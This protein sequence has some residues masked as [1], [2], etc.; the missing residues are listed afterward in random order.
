M[1]APRIAVIVVNYNGGHLVA[2]CLASVLRQTLA[3]ARVIVVDNGSSDGSAEAVRDRFRR[4]ELV[5][6]GGNI[7]FA[8]ASNLGAARAENCDW[9]ALLNPDAFPEPR[10]LE[11]LAAAASANPE[12]SSFGSRMLMD[13]DPSRFDGVGDVYHPSG[14]CWREAHGRPAAGAFE[15]PA[16]I[17]SPCAGAALYRRQVFL[18]SGGFDEDFFC[19]MEDVDLGF[20]LRLRGHRSLYVPDAVVRHKGSGIAGR[21]SDFALYH[22]HRNMVWTYVKN[23]PGPWFWAYLPLHLVANLLA[24]LAL[25]RPALRGKLHAAAALP[26]FWRKRRSVQ[27]ARRARFRDVSAFF[28]RGLLPLLRVRARFDR[29][30]RGIGRPRGG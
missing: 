26:R 10:W 9:I 25:G 7:G 6:A 30:P 13:D 23:M 27:G 28:S 1:T 18:E 15:T 12:Y 3:P 19:Y 29:Q 22:G 4:A 11:R 20:R 16:E 2:R 5:P 17:F 8:A 14:L 21:R 24:M